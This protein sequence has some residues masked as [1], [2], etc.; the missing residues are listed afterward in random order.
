MNNE[1]IK[2]YFVYKKY[3]KNEIKLRYKIIANNMKM[4][5][6]LYETVNSQ[7]YK[8]YPEIGKEIDRH[9]INLVKETINNHIKEINKKTYIYFY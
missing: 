2:S 5:D 7:S 3:I 9:N 4:L 1:A 8:T 6:Y